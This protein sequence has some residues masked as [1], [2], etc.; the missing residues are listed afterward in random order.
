[1][2][3]DAPKQ[4]ATIE[5]E[6]KKDMK[7]SLKGIPLW[8]G[9]LKNI[10]GVG[11]GLG[12][13]IIGELSCKRI[14]KKRCK[15]CE[16]KENPKSF[17]KKCEWETILRT[18]KDFPSTSHF[19]SYCGFGNNPDGTIHK[20]EKGKPAN[21]NNFLKMTLWKFAQNQI[22]QGRTYRKY[23]DERK[24]Y[25]IKRLDKKSRAT[26]SKS[27][28]LVNKKS[29]AILS[30]SSSEMNKKTRLHLSESNDPVLTKKHIHN[31]ACRY[32]IKRFLADLFH[33]WRDDFKGKL[34]E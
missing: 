26:L 28:S 19:Y 8:E 20:R 23:Y 22:K 10:R 34:P 31:R 6:I 9:F 24:K 14:L 5:A 29:R 18:A 16:K 13:A 30:K 33:F 32:F 7:R 25:E 21:W 17:C 11:E 27:M 2:G 1:M 15:D 4:L 12:S 3:Y